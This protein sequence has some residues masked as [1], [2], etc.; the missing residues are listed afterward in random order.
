MSKS[1]DEKNKS[2]E[3][4]TASSPHDTSNLLIHIHPQH[5]GSSTPQTHHHE[6]VSNNS[7]TNTSISHDQVAATVDAAIENVQVNP[8]N[9]TTEA[10]DV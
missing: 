10:F 2:H 9:P 6:S 7:V 5:D 1:E 3:T 8:K 4:T